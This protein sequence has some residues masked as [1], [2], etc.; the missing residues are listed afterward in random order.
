MA[1]AYCHGELESLTAVVDEAKLKEGKPHFTKGLVGVW[2]NDLPKDSVVWIENA[3]TTARALQELT[4]SKIEDKTP[5]GRLD[6]KFPPIQYPECD[7][8]QNS[9]GNTVRSVLRGLLAKF[10][11]KTKI[12]VINHQCHIAE[13]DK[14]APL[15]KNR[16]NRIEYFRSGKDRASNS[17]LN[18][19]LI[20]VLGTPRVPPSA[21]RDQLIRLGRIGSSSALTFNNS[22]VSFGSYVWEGKRMNGELVRVKDSVTQIINGKKLKMVV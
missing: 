14:L 19:D 16:I 3:S 13:I 2:K 5:F 22:F 15:W 7:I 10:S 8:T 6:Y 17:W 11:D 12:G 20:L 18:C 9:S 4:Q 1:L 21:I